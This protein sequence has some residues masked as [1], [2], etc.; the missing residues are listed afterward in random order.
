MSTPSESPALSLSSST[1]LWIYLIPLYVGWRIYWANR[2]P[3]MDCDE[4]YNYWEPLHF[5][6]YSSG[7]QTW[8]YANQFAL[9]TYAYLT[10]LWVLAKLFEFLVPVIPTWWWPV[11]SSQVLVTN[12]TI[13][14]VPLF[15]LLRASLAAGMAL[16]EL[17]FCR[18]ISEHSSNDAKSS[19]SSFIISV[20]TAGLLL[21]SAGMSHASGALLPSSTLTFLWLVASAAFLRHQ[22]TLFIIAAIMATLAIGWPFGVLMFVPMG[23]AILVREMKKPF[24]IA[25]KIVLI[26]ALIQTFVMLIDYANY[27]RLVS[28]TWNILLYNTKAGGDELYGIEPWT[29]YVKNLFLNFNYVILGVAVL[30][31]LLLRR[32]YTLLILLSPMY[33]WLLVVGPRPHKEERF[34]F[35]IYP[36]ICLGAAV[37]SVSLVEVLSQWYTKSKDMGTSASFLLQGVFWFPAA[38]FSL[39]RTLAL[40]KYY[41]APL[42]IYAQLQKQP[43]VVDSVVCTC[44]EWYR[45]PSSFYLPTAVGSSLRF[46]KS[47][48]QGQLPQPFTPGGGSGPN[49]STKFNDQNMPEPG[50]YLSIDDCDYL[51]DLWTSTDC[52]ENDSEWRPVARESFLDA[53]RTN[54]LHRILYI[55]FL[56]EKEQN[57]LGGVEYVDYVL[58]HR[59]L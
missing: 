58:Y 54:T 42:Y 24:A 56:H 49:V 11:L 48:F 44:G 33:L 13:S 30:P 27:G 5:L 21:S 2:L 52:R 20:T 28:P 47:S 12:D 16:A 4:V 26:T 3:I 59:K 57:D 43:Y 40:S 22:H 29:Y 10:P 35:P 9:R 19:T 36:C 41:T 25:S 17:F 15:L 18:A 8:E 14:R 7:F 31:I 32:R 37:V 23:L 34:L 53:D 6:L 39:S 55:P 45:F 38:I 46:L 50:S 1:S 51:V